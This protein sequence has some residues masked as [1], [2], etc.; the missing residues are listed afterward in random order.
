L[1]ATTGVPV[2]WWRS[3]ESSMN[4]FAVES[5]LDEL[6]AASKADP[7]AYRLALLA[8]PRKVQYPPDNEAV[9]DT[10]RFK[11]VLE[12]AAEKA[13]WGRPLPKGRARGIAAHFSFLSYVAEVAEVSLEGG[14]PRVHR[15]VAAVDIGRVVR[16]D[17]VR[18]QVEGAI[19]YGLTA[20]LKGAITVADGKCVQSNFHDFPM[21]RIAEMPEVEVHIVPSTEAPTGIGEPGL[22]PIAPAVMNALFALTGKRVR[23]LPV[24][25]ED[26]A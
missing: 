10:T 18:A 21:L 2:M 19:V 13:G 3:V 1:A 25:A 14:H 11:R 15:V 9:L 17:S 23:R 20:A 16:P 24:R 8:E 4:A 12:M 26:L 5:F 6:A 22:P 7:L